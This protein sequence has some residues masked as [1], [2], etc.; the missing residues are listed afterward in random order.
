[1][2]ERSRIRSGMYK[3]QCAHVEIPFPAAEDAGVL[4]QVRQKR[5]ASG[6]EPI[7]RPAGSG[8]ASA[9]PRLGAYL[10]VPDPELASTVLMPAMSQ[11]VQPR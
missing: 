8:R 5:V 1:M 7:R 11:E 3:P 9:G 10:A 2:N 4:P 6:L